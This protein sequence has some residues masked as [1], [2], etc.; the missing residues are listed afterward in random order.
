M[1]DNSFI[2]NIIIGPLLESTQC[3][4]SLPMQHQ[5]KHGS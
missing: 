5:L 1:I 4:H 2:L 3:L